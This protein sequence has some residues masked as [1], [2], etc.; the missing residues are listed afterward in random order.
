MHQVSAIDLLFNIH[1]Q[2][3][4]YWITQLFPAKLSWGCYHRCLSSFRG[5]HR[6]SQDKLIMHMELED[7]WPFPF[8]YQTHS[9]CF[10]RIL[11]E[12]GMGRQY[13]TNFLWVHSSCSCILLPIQIILVSC[14]LL[15][16]Y[17]HVRS[18][19]AFLLN[20]QTQS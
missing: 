6:Q 10:T 9:S 14:H 15:P 1:T 20:T 12:K 17:F 18:I 4:I 5:E 11:R 3:C 16:F 8:R 2:G 19:S 13:S 7:K